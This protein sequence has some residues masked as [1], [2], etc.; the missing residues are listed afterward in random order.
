MNRSYQYRLYPTKTQI[1]SLDFLRRQACTLYNAALE[2]RRE[3]WKM[4]RV[5]LNYY[6]QANQLKAIRSDDPH[7]LGLLNFSAC[8]QVLRRVQKTYSAFFQRIKQGKG[9]FPRFKPYRRFRS[10]DFRYGDG[11]HLA[12]GRLAVQNVGPI[13]VKWHRPLPVNAVVKA[14]VVTC[15]ATGKWF[16][17]FQ[18][19]LSDVLPPIHASLAVGIDLGLSTLAAL[20]TGECIRP[21]RYFRQ[22]EK[23]LRR[24]QRHLARCKRVSHRRKAVVRQVAVTH[25]HVANQRKDFAHKLSTRLVKDFSLIAVEDLNIKGI[26]KSR[27]AKSTHDAG[28]SMLLQQLAY[29]ASS[30]G[31]QF[32]AVDPYNTSQ[33]CS[34]CGSIVKKSLGVR[35]HECPECGLVL[36]RDINAARNIL[37]RALSAGT[38][39]SDANVEVPDSCVV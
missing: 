17:C 10:L 14:V 20:S 7:G 34:A 27:L 33:A 22:A 35:V 9:G 23:L 5:S 21:P 4:R 16:I 8:Q 15:D 24:Q 37:Y 2:E 39:L 30:A 36:D 29:K 31:V 18:I 13:R 32:I 11:V 25:A 3:A 28:W 6:D 1:T 38:L 12:D 26:T 19:E